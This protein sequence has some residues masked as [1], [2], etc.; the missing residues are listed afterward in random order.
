MKKRISLVLLLV[1]ALGLSV[2]VGFTEILPTSTASTNSV[3]KIN[4]GNHNTIVE[5]EDISV[6]SEIVEVTTQTTPD[7]NV[8]TEGINS[9][10]K[11]DLIK[12][13]FDK[14]VMES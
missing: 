14:N 2:I 9:E 6:V 4:K 12:N 10:I 1:L 7:E 11:T 5:N 8:S 3:E 13:Y